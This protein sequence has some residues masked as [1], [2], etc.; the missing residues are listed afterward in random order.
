MCSHFGLNSNQFYCDYSL[1]IHRSFLQNVN[2]QTLRTKQVGKWCQ[3]ASRWTVTQFDG[4][5]NVKTSKQ[6]MSCTW[7]QMFWPQ[8]ARML[9]YACFFFFQHSKLNIPE[10]VTLRRVWKQ[11]W[12]P[13]WYVLPNQSALKLATLISSYGHFGSP[14]W[15]AREVDWR[16]TLC[17]I[18]KSSS[19]CLNPFEV[20]TP[21]GK[22]L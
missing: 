15:F 19:L 13:N 3:S 18:Q 9:N 2:I 6:T 16:W 1:S 5:I 12:P 21:K 8:N 14:W 7:C 4:R 22:P 11:S 20:F 17:S 10:Y